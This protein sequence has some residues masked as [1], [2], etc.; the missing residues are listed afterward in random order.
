MKIL[1]LFLTGIYG[2]MAQGVPRYPMSEKN[3]D[4]MTKAEL[5]GAVNKIGTVT[6]KYKAT[7]VT[8]TVHSTN[9]TFT[10]SEVA[11]GPRDNLKRSFAANYRN[12]DGSAMITVGFQYNGAAILACKNK[13]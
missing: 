7:V 9:D 10:Y 4:D 13:I 1:M 12:L 3:L 8:S 5:V 6:M 2:L 11:K